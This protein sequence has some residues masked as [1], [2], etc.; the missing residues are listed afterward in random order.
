MNH[1]N[2]NNSKLEIRTKEGYSLDVYLS[3]EEAHSLLRELERFYGRP[4]EI[5]R[6]EILAPEKVSFLDESN[7][8]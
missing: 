8:G 1:F 6:E 5:T 2:V 7:G 4:Q 3:K